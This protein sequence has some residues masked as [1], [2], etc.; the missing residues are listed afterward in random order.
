MVKYQRKEI[1]MAEKKITPTE[2]Q[3]QAEQ[4]LKEGKMPNAK[5]LLEAVAKV[6][7]KYGPAIEKARK[8]KA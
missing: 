1:A 5:A 4:L 6:R 3:A 2:L 8:E 7:K